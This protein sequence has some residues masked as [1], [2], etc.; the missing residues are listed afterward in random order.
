MCIV[1]FD[2]QP[3][4]PTPLRLAANRDEFHARPAEPARWRGD[5]FCGLDLSAGGTWLGIHRDGRMAVVTNFREPIAERQ[6]GERS[7]GQLPLAF[8]QGHEGPRDFCLALAE[9]Q[10]HYGAFNLL[11]GDRHQLWYL[12]NRG[13]APR[14]VAPG[15]HGLCN[16]LLDDPWPKVERGKQ[17]LRDTLVGPH[18]LAD[19]LAVVEDPYQ[20]DDAHL[21]DTGVGLELER[22]VAPIFI[23]S[24]QY[25]TRASSAVII[26]SQGQ[27]RMR[28][29]GWSPEGQPLGAPCDSEG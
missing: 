29:Q 1:L 21:P 28:E 10:H 19:L 4:S 25:G 22:L 24:P 8:L 15:L 9:Q 16:G 14:A 12:G 27:P 5:I 7:R 2:W 23:Q 6:A 3:G 17:R 13:A 20:P 26:G 18:D 11:V